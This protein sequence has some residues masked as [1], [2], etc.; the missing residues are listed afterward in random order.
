MEFNDKA[1]VELAKKILDLQ[2]A[3]WRYYAVIIGIS[4]LGALFFAWLKSYGTE[5]GK[6]SAIA[7]NFE[8]IKMQLAETTLTTKN[9]EL[10]LGHSD[11]MAKEYKTLRRAKLEELLFS[12]YEAENWISKIITSDNEIDGFNAEHSPIYKFLVISQLYF[13]ELKDK[14]DKIYSLH[15]SFV[16]TLLDKLRPI[17]AAHLQLKHLDVQ[18]EIFQKMPDAA[19]RQEASLV[20]RRE[21]SANYVDARAK[22][23]EAL[24]VIYGEVA[25]SFADIRTN[26]E[27]IM[28]QT[29]GENFKAL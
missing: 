27:K 17:R 26:I 28:H 12:S 7:S 19:A 14:R 10:A 18:W 4:F 11:W 29:I 25:R 23:H 2:I 22:S 5:K 6:I 21:V 9:I 13:P 8:Q 20:E 3:D 15:Q 24:I 16:V 1:V